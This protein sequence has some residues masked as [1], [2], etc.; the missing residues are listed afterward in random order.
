MRILALDWGTVRVGAAISDPDQT[1]AF[2]LN[3]I[4]P[5]KTA[6]EEIKK[7]CKE[8]EVEMILLGLPK[9]LSNTDSGSTKKVYEYKVELEQ[10]TNLKV[11]LIDERLS[12]VGAQKALSSAGLNEKKQKDIKDNVVAQLMLQ[13]YLDQKPIKN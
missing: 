10:A 9:T 2:P 3:R 8:E 12:S 1:I 4:I 7:I 5:G 11:E 13:S 6:I